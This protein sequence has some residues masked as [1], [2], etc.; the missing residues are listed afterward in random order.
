[1]W[2][3]IKRNHNYSINKDGRVRNDKTGLIKQPFKNKQNG[4]LI[5][6]LYKNNKSEK[7]PIHRLVAEAFIPNPGKKLTV[8]HIDGNRENNSIE[9]LRWATYSENNSRF[10]TI[11]VRSESII[12]TRYA[13]E[14]NKRG[15]GHL[16]WLDI[17]DTMEF[18]SVSET[19]KYFDC[20][21]SNISLMLEKG[22]IGRRGRTRGYRFSYKNGGRSKILKV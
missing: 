6:D 3:K 17:I 12:V 11:G 4:Y 20:T 21:I 16:A 15:G 14:R 10:E 1:M 9:N 8:D 2:K 7:V 22:T 18:E 13:E 19:A 5:V